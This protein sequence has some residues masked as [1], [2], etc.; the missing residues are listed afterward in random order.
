MDSGLTG[1]KEWPKYKCHKEVHALKIHVMKPP[2]G[3]EQGGSGEWL[4]IP[5]DAGHMGV[6]VSDA[7]VKK[8][9]PQ[10]GGYLVVYEDGYRSYSPAEPFEKGYT[11][12]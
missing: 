1:S 7:Y 3:V 5:L 6:A 10:S 11:R 9:D 2:I 8:H 12:V 4:M